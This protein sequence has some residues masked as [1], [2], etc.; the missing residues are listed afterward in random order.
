[1]KIWPI[2]LDSRPPYLRG[3]ERG[4][5]LLLSLLGTHTV[6]EH[7]RALLD[8]LTA[9]APLMV[10]RD[11]YDADYPDLIRAVCPT[12]H[13]AATPEELEDAVASYELSDVMLIVDPR[14]L[15]LRTLEL[16]KFVQHASYGGLRIRGR[17]HQGA[18]QLRCGGPGP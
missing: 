3:R 1:M 8:P 9:H 7:L 10:A 15:P 2:V 18:R 11:S 17:R 4:R 16:S 6:I 14:C 5:S 12:A 13:V